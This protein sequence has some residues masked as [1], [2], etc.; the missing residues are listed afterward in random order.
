[1]G[2]ALFTIVI[3]NGMLFA[4]LGLVGARHAMRDPSP[5]VRIF[6][7]G[8][9]AVCAAFV[10]SAATR[11]AAL[12]VREGWLP[13]R[14]GDFLVSEWSFVQ[15]A[16]ASLFALT[17]I[18][19]LR[20]VGGPMRRADQIVTVLSDRFPPEAPISELGLTARELE[21]LEVIS[22]G[23]TSNK[24]IAEALYIS[25]ATAGTHVKNI[26]RKAGVNDRRDLM[27]FAATQ[28]R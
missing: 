18:W 27:L 20:R 4:T 13:G 19:F 12:A 14:V 15:S 11:A 25:P 28:D 6:A 2:V 5:R 16:A 1:M 24:D 3:V 10:L 22:A 26:L 17:A 23:T 21:V 7:G 8:F 9:T